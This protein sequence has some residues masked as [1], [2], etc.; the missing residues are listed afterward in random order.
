MHERLFT[1]KLN[2]KLFKE[3]LLIKTVELTK[4]KRSQLG[5][6]EGW[7]KMCSRSDSLRNVFEY[8]FVL[9]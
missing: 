9:G 8:E 4:E 5:R 3:I 6:V 2:K 1:P 7:T